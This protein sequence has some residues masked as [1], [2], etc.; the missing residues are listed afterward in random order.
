MDKEYRIRKRILEYAQQQ[1]SAIGYSNVS[2]AQLAAEL[3]MS[4]STLYKY[5][6]SKEEL[7]FAVID[8]FYQTFE[9]E[10][11][12][13]VQDDRMGVTAQVS[14]F[15]Q[16]VRK[17][18]SQ[19]QASVVEDMRRSVPEA[20]A[21]LEQRRQRII[22][23]TLIGMFEQGVKDGLFRSDIPPVIIVNVL[24]QALRYLEDPLVIGDLSYNY[25]D[26]FQQVFS[27]VME[28]S[29]TE[30]GREGMKGANLS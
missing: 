15:I 10:I 23:D 26:M 29:L 22:T 18:F 7:L 3:K 5:F 27:I 11:Q 9:Q 20:Y 4:K 25:A 19:L 30:Q 8:D 17:R 21:R 24:L 2:T 16:S 14:T 28:G 12:G 1:F 6:A 13:I